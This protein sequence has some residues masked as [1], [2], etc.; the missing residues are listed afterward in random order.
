MT[1][2]SDSN[3]A[4]RRLPD[5]TTWGDF[6]DQEFFQELVRDGTATWTTDEGDHDAPR[7]EGSEWVWDDAVYRVTYDVVDE[8]GTPVSQR[9]FEYSIERLGSTEEWGKRVRQT[10]AFELSDL[11]ESGREIVEHAIGL[12][13]P[14]VR[15]PDDEEPQA[16][17]TNAMQNLVHQFLDHEPLSRNS[18]FPEG[19]GSA[20]FLVNYEGRTYWTEISFD[21]DEFS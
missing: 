9:T 17:P 18:G 19:G 15:F 20:R 6:R 10:Y 2:I 5:A 11:S 21:A 7:P 14:Y 1:A 12:D 16:T 13:T 4:E 8:S 3:I